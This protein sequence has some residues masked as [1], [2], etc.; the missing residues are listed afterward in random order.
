MATQLLLVQDVENLGRSGE[1][2]KVRPGFARNY[3]IPKGRAVI[4][5]KNALRMQER[6]KEERL[7]KAAEDLKGS[8]EVSKRIEGQTLTKMVKVDHEG[9]LY[10]SVSALDIQHL[11]ES[12]L[13]VELEKRS[14]VLKHPIKDLGVFTISVKLKEEVSC[15]F[16]LKVISEAGSEDVPAETPAAE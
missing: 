4:A 15:S 2:V 12:S 3:L 10:G 5:D 13:N 6:L 8:E 11:L 7:K 14:I 9:H 1:I 16:T